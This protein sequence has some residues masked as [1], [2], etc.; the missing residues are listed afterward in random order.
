MNHGWHTQLLILS[1]SVLAVITSAVAEEL[2]AAPAPSAA[3][4]NQEVSQSQIQPYADLPPAANNGQAMAEIAEALADMPGGP[5]EQK[6]IIRVSDAIL[7]E[8]NAE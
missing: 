4:Q 3:P 2:K 5:T 6:Q 8:L 1:A 7:N